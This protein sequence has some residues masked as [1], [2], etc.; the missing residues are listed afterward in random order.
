MN[1]IK[2]NTFLAALIVVVVVGVAVF[3]FLGSSALN[4][5]AEASGKYDQQANELKRLQN[6]APYPSEENLAKFREQKGALADTI[7]ALATQLSAIRF[8]EEPLRPNEFQDRL[9][10]A[11]SATVEKAKTNGVKLPENFYL[12]ENEYQTTLPRD[13]STAAALGFELQ[14]IQFVVNELIESK[15]DALTALTRLPEPAPAASPTPRPGSAPKPGGTTAAPQKPLVQRRSFD[16]TFTIEQPRLRKFLNSVT[17]SKSQFYILRTIRIRNQAEKGPSRIDV[18]AEGGAASG[19]PAAGQVAPGQEASKPGSLKFIV[20][21]ELLEVA[22]RIEIVQFN[23]P[24][25][26]PAR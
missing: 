25:P 22:A 19:I 10:A 23:P 11:V 9:R 20:G 2:E 17:S 14:A 24:A 16:L 21:T 12:G 1:W 15:A 13:E 7:N 4:R 8:P 18:T 5:F 6:L 3:G 26:A